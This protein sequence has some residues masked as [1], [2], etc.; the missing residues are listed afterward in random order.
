MKLRLNPSISHP[1]NLQLK[2]Q[3]RTLNSHLQRKVQIIKLNTPR[4]RQ[5]RKQTPGDSV[6]ICRE[7]THVF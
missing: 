1:I 4:S 3:S 2:A 6:K 5:S 7:S